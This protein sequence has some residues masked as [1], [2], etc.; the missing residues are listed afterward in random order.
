MKRSDFFK[1]LLGGGAALTIAPQLLKDSEKKIEEFHNAEQEAD[2]LNG[3]E[4][5]GVSQFVASDSFAG[6][7]ACLSELEMD[8]VALSGKIPKV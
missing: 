5:K 6:D 2:R 3:F 8:K 4:M 7:A 1:T